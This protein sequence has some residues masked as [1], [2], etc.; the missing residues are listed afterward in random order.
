MARISSNVGLVTGLNIEE[1]VQ[2]LMTVAARPRDLLKSRNDALKQEQTALDTLGSRLLAFQFAANKLKASSVFTTRQAT[3]SKPDVLQVAIPASGT[4]TLGSFQVRPVQAA[5]SQ[6]LVSQ[7]FDAATTEL[8][9]G[10]FSF[11]FGG[12]VD[13]GISL[14]ELNGGAGVPRG[15]IRITDRNGDSAVIDLTFARTVDDVLSAIN[16]NAEIAVTAGVDG[17]SFTL[18]DVSGGSGN[19]KVAE[20]GGTTAAGLGWAGL[21]VAAAEATGAD[22]F[23][24]HAG[25]KLRALN[26]GNGVAVS[27][28]GVVDLDVSLADGSTL[29]IDLHDA[30]TLGDVIEQINA[31][32][33][34]KLSS[35][36]SADGNRIELTDLTVG[37]G[38]FTVAD[39]VASSA[40]SDLGLVGN[41]SG[42]L[43]GARLASGLRDTLL[44]SLNG[45][46]GLGDLGQIQITDRNGGYAT[47][48][49]AGAETL[50]DVV[51]AINASA[52]A[53]TA[54]VNAARNG[55]VVRDASG[56][57]GNL[58]LVDLDATNTAT[59][60]GIALNAAESAVDSGALRKQTLSRAT[61]LES[62]NGGS[63]LALG[64]IQITDTSGAVGFADLNAAG[65]EART[66]GDV[67]D[68]INALSIGVEARI[69]DAGDGVLLVDSAGGAGALG[70]KD[71]SGDVAKSLHL[72]RASGTV[73]V[74]GVPRTAIDGAM[75]FSVDLDDLE[76]SNA[77][78]ALSSL[79]GGLGVAAGDFTI[80]DS[81]EKTL[82]L[83]LNGADAGITTVG[84]LI[85]AI[86]AKA[87][88]GGVGVTAR[89]ND[90][91]TGIRLED[92]AGGSKKLTVTDLNSSAA[93]DLR[94]AGEAVLVGGKQVING[95]GAFAAVSGVQTG[96]AALAAKINSL[97]AGVTASTVFDGEG[98]RLSLAVDA[99]GAARELLIDAG[100]SGLTFE[101][102]A[103]AQDA[104]LLYGNLSSS[105]GGVLVS[106]ADNT[107][108]GALGG[109]DVTITE[110][111]ETP[112]TV[113]VAQT[114]ASLVD[115]V[116]D[117][118]DAYNA[119]RTDLAKLTAFDPEALTTGLLFGRSEVVQIDSQ[120]SRA[121]TNRY[122]G[123]GDFQS[124]EEIGLSVT[125]DGKLS[126]DKTRLKS[127]FQKNPDGVQDFLATAE[128]GVVAKVAAVVDRLAGA[129]ESI[130]AGRSD[131]LKTSIAANEDRL[132]AFSV[133]LEK[134]Q[135]RLLLQFYQLETIIARLQQ[136]Q[137]A[138]TALQPLAPLGS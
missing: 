129:K 63:G 37:A 130:L 27:G 2:K 119:L 125:G 87:T 82:A 58:V 75:S 20:V 90:A 21:N 121:L 81:A 14:D 61:L 42:T 28:E 104:L 53:V 107:I 117:M 111:S 40:A 25:K 47:I 12:F 83:D 66:V 134:Q 39:G 126:L 8:G 19:L 116:E 35:A 22:V 59:K 57:G 55:L 48:N 135:E 100:D 10:Q 24:L 96:L 84:Q 71:L 60:L 50:G 103:K 114:D 78:I 6:Q 86:N 62:L 85:D 69:N 34:A 7:R 46:Q 97:A 5:S 132:E 123:L 51:A 56:G 31:V 79:N 124:L 98:Y 122:L 67:I 102:T 38:D 101:E 4:P 73:E 65:N 106:S 45:G 108:E 15:K 9:D 93:A 72:T 64:D 110:S 133:Q 109:V 11:R 43:A 70:V 76:V 131:S 137:S 16:S 91:G 29:G 112:I 115:S 138:L 49:L 33:G 118:V 136:S 80:T 26:D 13:K 99:T 30:V 41:A 105:S 54:S 18:A 128:T 1:T 95:A 89:L 44:A 94:I 88:A 74:G 52:A 120:L 127:A 92:T 68:A 113:T 17:D 3:S 23:R 36:I 32:D 77:S